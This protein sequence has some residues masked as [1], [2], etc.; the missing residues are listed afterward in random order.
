[1]V[2]LGLF[3]SDR[4]AAALAVE[5][6]SRRFA[7]ALAPVKSLPA[8]LGH[9]VAKSVLEHFPVLGPLAV[10]PLVGE[11]GLGG[12]GSVKEH[13][14][15]ALHASPRVSSVTSLAIQR[16]KDADRSLAREALSSRLAAHISS[17]A[18]SRLFPNTVRPFAPRSHLNCNHTWC[19]ALISRISRQSTS[20][21]SLRF[22]SP[23]ILEGKPSPCPS[24]RP[25]S[26]L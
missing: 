24:L 17:H 22:I 13:W 26:R 12:R 3:P 1:M 4:R 20:L 18:A 11:H 21:R 16:V 23:D 6:R 25:A 7:K 9:I 15:P 2:H 10:G 8:K 5:A 14:L 19:P